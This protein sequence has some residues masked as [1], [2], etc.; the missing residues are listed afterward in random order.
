MTRIGVFGGTFD[1]IHVGHLVAAQ[2]A[3]RALELDRILF[4][5]AAEP[6]HKKAGPVSDA[7]LRE[8]M[9]RAAVGDDTRFEVSDVEIRRGGASYTV[10]T[11]RTL[12]EFHARAQLYLIIGADQL[13]ELDT[14][15]EPRELA[16]LAKLAV[17]SRKGEDP[18][19]VRAPLD[20]EFERMSVTRVDISSTLIRTRV[21]AG[22]PV[23]YLVPEAVRRI[24]ER[25]G[26]Y[27]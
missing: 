4:I 14:W 1:P 16:R 22:E 7:R 24:I 8:E 21:A 27:A 9:V 17:M 10:D 19:A 13:A 20:V 11:L 2:D 15:K 5:P 12:L 18:E 3:H 6:P 26:L 23:R 25:E